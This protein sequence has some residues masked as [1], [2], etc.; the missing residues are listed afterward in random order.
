MSTDIALSLDDVA[1]AFGT[2]VAELPPEV[3]ALIG[4]IDL[5]FRLL[6]EP[7]RD[8]VILGILQKLDANAF[9]EVGEHRHDVW[10]KGWT[11]NLG[12]FVGE[13]P[14]LDSLMPRFI[15]PDQAVRLNKQFVLPGDP[16]FEWHYLT[17]FH[18]WLFRRYCGGAKAIY[19]FGCGSGYNLVQL[20]KI[21]SSVKLVGLDWADSAVQLV[22]S[23][24]SKHGLNLAGRHFD[25]FHP[26]TT[27]CME[28]GSVALT[29]CALEQIGDRFEEFL[30]FLLSQSPRLCVHH[31]ANL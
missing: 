21:F 27:L 11:E 8:Q 5:R 9:S 29:I 28:P 17:A 4:R 20:A 23:V 26:D 10:E 22:N 7:R 25:F 6:D 15:R 12:D 16:A 18:E 14:S 30:Q 2:D 13:G 3:A 24:G 1:A 31:E 19:E